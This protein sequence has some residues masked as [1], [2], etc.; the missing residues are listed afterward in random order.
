VG[1]SP[2][3]QIISSFGHLSADKWDPYVSFAVNWIQIGDL[4]ELQIDLREYDRFLFQ[5][6]KVVIFDKFRLKY[7][8]FMLTTL[9]I[10]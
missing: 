4:L 1:P 6:R 10:L 9:M 2:I 5:K 8:N 7:G 3:Q